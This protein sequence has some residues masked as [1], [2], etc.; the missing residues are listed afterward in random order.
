MKKALLLLFLGILTT[1]LF[2]QHKQYNQAI[3]EGNYLFLEKNYYMALQSYEEAYRID[4]MNANINYKMGL[5][6]LNIP[7]KK[8]KAFRFLEKASKNISKSYDEDEPGMKTAPVDAIY[9]HAR[10]QHYSGNFQ[11]AIDEYQ[12][13][14]KSVGL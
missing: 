12:K 1:N 14:Q 7:S 6:Y 10:A 13:Y 9:Y 8:K 4:S 2:S 5:C 11:L 3:T